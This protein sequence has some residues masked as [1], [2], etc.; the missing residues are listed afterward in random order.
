MGPDPCE[1]GPIDLLGLEFEDYG[2]HPLTYTGPVYAVRRFG[3]D[4]QS[5]HRFRS[6]FRRDVV[7]HS[8]LCLDSC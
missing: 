4:S 7:V 5:C 8:S 3:Y 1:I 6:R 2:E